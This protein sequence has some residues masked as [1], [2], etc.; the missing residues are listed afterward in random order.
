MIE[1]NLIKKLEKQEQQLDEI[2]G[3]VKKLKRYFLATIIISFLTFLLPILAVILS[4]PWL[5]E[6]F[7]T[8]TGS[9]LL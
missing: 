2:Y 6:T 4:L 3:T 8:I 5:M 7:Q 9:G 1:E